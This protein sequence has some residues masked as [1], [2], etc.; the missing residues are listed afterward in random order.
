MEAKPGRSF[1]RKAAGA[2][3]ASAAGGYIQ[4]KGARPGSHGVSLVSTGLDDL[5]HIPL[6]FLLHF[7][8]V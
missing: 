1:V 5:D 2:A 7:D 3:A 8:F 6:C 4:A